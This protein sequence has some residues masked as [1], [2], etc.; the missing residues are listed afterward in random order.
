MCSE[1]HFLISIWDLI[2]E[3]S[4]SVKMQHLR[5]AMAKHCRLSCSPLGLPELSAAG[6]SLEARRRHFCASSTSEDFTSRVLE[7][8][9]K[10]DRID[11]NKVTEKA[12]FRKDLNLDSLDRVELVMAI[13]QE[14]LVE[15]PD[16]KGDK[17]SCCADVVKYISE[18][19]SVEKDCS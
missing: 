1:C 2:D 16:E 15:I 6:R 11:A 9:K 5:N 13:E 14:F 12:D 17:L 8:V 19:R 18:T 3:I 10:F 7:V 4:R